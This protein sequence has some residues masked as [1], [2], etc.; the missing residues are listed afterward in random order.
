M[1]LIFWYG[2]KWEDLYYGIEYATRLLVKFR[3]FFGLSPRPPASPAE[4]TMS[5]SD[6][7]EFPLKCKFCNEKIP[8]SYGAFVWLDDQIGAHIRCLERW[9]Y[10]KFEKKILVN[11]VRNENS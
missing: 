3:K 9:S 5:W 11:R 7:I 4:Y 1:D 6:G 10:E 8:R 2:L